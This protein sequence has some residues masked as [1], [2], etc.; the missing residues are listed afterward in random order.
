LHRL[1]QELH[2][3]HLGMR[4]STMNSA[5]SDPRLLEFIDDLQRLRAGTGFDD[6]ERSAEMRVE[7]A[8]DSVQ[9][10]RF[11]VDRQDDRL[12]H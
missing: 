5:T 9:D 11:V 3:G 2:A 1:A 7:V 10:V 4:S 12:A 6:P 8:F